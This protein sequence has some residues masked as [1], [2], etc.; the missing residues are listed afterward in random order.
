MNKILTFTFIIILI[1]SATQAQWQ[2]TNGPEGIY[3]TS[4]FDE[5]TILLC[6]TYAQGV[7]RS[8]D[9]GHSWTVSNSG[10]QNK[11]VDCFAKDSLYIYA[12]VF[13]EGVFRSSDNGYTWLPANTGIQ[14]QAVVCLLIADGFLFAGTVGN[15][16]YR[17]PDHGNT[18]ADANG[19]AL[20]G[21]Y[22]LAMVCQDSRLMVEADNYIFY[23]YDDGN[24]WYVDQG[25]TQFY[26][27][28]NFFQHGDTLL[29]STGIILFRSTDGGVN[30][31]APDIMTHSM[32]GFDNTGDTIYAGS[33]DGIF[34]SIDYGLNW[35]F[36]LSSDL[37]HGARSLDDFVISDNN[38]LY[39]YE[40]I[41]VYKSQD[42]GITWQQTPLSD[43]AVASNIDDA[44]IFD[45][46][47]VY[48]GTHTNGVYKTTDQGNTWT[49]IGTPV[50]ADTLSNEVIFDMLHVGNS[51]LFAGGCGTGL[52]RS[53]DNG[54]T[55]THI[56]SGL[57]PDNGN[58]TCVKTLA[59]CGP[60]LLCAMTNGVF[61][62]VD[63]GINWN[64]T[65]LTGT[66]VLQ[67]GGFAVRGNIACVGIIGFPLQTGVYRSTD[68]GITW[69]LA[70]PILDIETMATGG[71]HTM[72]CGELFTSY[73]SYNDGL[74][75]NGLGL[76][77]AFSILAWNNFAF[78][79]NNDGVYFSNNYGNSWT[80][81]NQGFDPYPNNA[82][83]GLTRDSQFVYAGTYR[84]GVWR[85][86]LSDF[87]ITTGISQNNTPEQT[88]SIAP[89]PASTFIKIMLP[90]SVKEKYSVTIVNSSGQKV[91]AKE[92]NGPDKNNFLSVYVKNFSPGLYTIKIKSE[93]KIFKSK[94]IKSNQE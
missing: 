63:S 24:S 23:S 15:G 13:G 9:H 25:T 53:A 16:L 42:K 88:I 90:S 72:Y 11:W 60:N 28:D 19:G 68:Y 84:D 45:N 2:K 75:W 22:I 74:T 73:V 38:F 43:F 21:S 37:R 55:W 34:S 61:Y 62:S 54:S 32:I 91:L 64:A 83:Q 50:P 8:Y 87:G 30:W 94:F 57:P 65:N 31:S 51:I 35:T 12:G 86:P 52:F 18:W 47:T 5:D 67:A 48:T 17:S 14:T 76:G 70:D 71:N 26:V 36:T 82:V 66:G 92:I 59:E 46:G 89:N 44:M 33:P 78:I 81:Y 27:I 58:F 3:V 39:A 79:G 29:A 80:P 4:F 69:T 49:K 85:R 56:T 41:G 93:Q 6:G 20:G 77:A 10:L 40:E 1:T 7:Y